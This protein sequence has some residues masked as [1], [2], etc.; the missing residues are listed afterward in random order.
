[1]MLCLSSLAFGTTFIG[2]NLFPKRILSSFIHDRKERHSSS[3]SPRW[4]HNIRG[5]ASDDNEVVANNVSLKDL[6]EKYPP[7]PQLSDDPTNKRA[8]VIVDSFCDYHGGYV[9]KQAKDVYNVTVIHALS[10]YV[11]GYMIQSSGAD[12]TE[13][14]ASSR[15]PLTQE[16]CKLWMEDLQK[17]FGIEEICGIYCESDSGLQ[18]VEIFGSLVGIKQ[19]DGINEARRNKYLM[20]QQISQ[21][22]LSSVQQKMCYS[23]EE[24]M[25]FAQ[26][27]FSN[28]D[29]DNTQKIGTLQQNLGEDSNLGILGTA[30][31]VDD[32]QKKY[33]VVKPCRGV[34]SDG[35]Y[36]C[37]DL[38]SVTK[39]FETIQGSS[40]FGSSLGEKHAGVLIQEFAMGTEYAID[41]VTKN[42]HSKIAALW[43]Y[44]KRP[45]NGAPFVYHATELMDAANT[46]VGQDI[47][48]YLQKVLNILKIGWGISH[49]EVI[50]SPSGDIKLVEVN[51]RQHAT[52]FAP[53][54]S[55]CIGYNALDMVLDAYLGDGDEWE[56]I[57]DLP[58]TR[59]YGAIVHLVSHVEGVVKSLN[60]DAL[61]EIS[62]QE[63][64]VAME[65]YPEIGQ[66]VGKTIDIRS[67]AGWI[68]LIHP[69]QSTFLDDYN[70][71]IE[72]M[73]H[74]FTTH[75]RQES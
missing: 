29:Y 41:V 9:A 8:I 2:S 68:H 50:V 59:L 4:N 60:I 10:T 13:D 26:H 38:D 61:E 73:P 70:R 67:D 35:V 24:A 65:V 48:A 20:N 40:I 14:I 33:C 27:L 51:C 62:S 46:K 19:H 49:C 69:S 64:V 21:V 54:T 75:P 47:Y 43:R 22:G 7:K 57:P 39:A 31:N 11:T 37:N 18:D 30:S 17:N 42:G 15:L 52:D 12:Q 71:I 72:L 45:V 66:P 36:L 16:D 63:S 1:M 34:A 5:G 58:T 3:S 55:A 32:S 56:E 44:D 23:L 25:D 53:L 28:Y 74:L 6:L